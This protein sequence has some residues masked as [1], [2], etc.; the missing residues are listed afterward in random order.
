[1]G[2]RSLLGKAVGP[3]VIP[4]S[5][6]SGNAKTA[7]NNSSARVVVPV[8][9][10]SFGTQRIR[11]SRGVASLK[12]L[13]SGLIRRRMSVAVVEGSRWAFPLL[14]SRAGVR[15]RPNPHL[16]SRCIP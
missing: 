7:D 2:D 16:Y 5:D 9:S 15:P 6:T 4:T 14:P 3:G 11:E 10:A 1:M 13:A 12:L 8:V